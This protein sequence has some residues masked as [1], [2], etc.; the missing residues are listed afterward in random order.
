[1]L[2]GVHGQ[3]VH[4]HGED[5]GR[6]G[7]QAQAR[8]RDRD[9]FALPREMHEELVGDEGVQTD[10]LGHA[11]HQGVEH[12]GEG[13]GPPVEM[14]DVGFHGVARLGR[15]ADDRP[16]HRQRVAHLVA[17]LCGQTLLVEEAAQ[18][19]VLGLQLLDTCV[20]RILVH[21]LAVR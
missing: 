3:F 17:Q 9:L 16:Q 7:A 2:D 10:P 15:A 11:P 18:A 1:M 4:R 21:G 12:A 19:P 13:I 20:P 5:L 14:G 6:S 8:S